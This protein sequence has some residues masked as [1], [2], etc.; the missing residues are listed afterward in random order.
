V[1][2]CGSG[3][4]LPARQASDFPARGRGRGG[5]VEAIRQRATRPGPIESCGNECWPNYGTVEREVAWAVA[6]TY[7]AMSPPPVG[8]VKLVEY[9]L[10]GHMDEL[11]EDDTRNDTL[12][13]RA[14]LPESS[15]ALVCR[16]C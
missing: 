2:R 5:L 7:R 4:I 15:I 12:L 1:E 16:L 11:G 9:A 10:T 13:R 14:F 8:A 3:Q 6:T